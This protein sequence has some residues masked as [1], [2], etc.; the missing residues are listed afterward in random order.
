M[1][2]GIC[3]KLRKSKY[4]L[5]ENELRPYFSLDNARDGYLPYQIN[6]TELHFTR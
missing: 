1:T 5:D 6:F 4:D 2:G 3:E